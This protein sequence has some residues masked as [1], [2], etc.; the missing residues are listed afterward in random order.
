M[1]TAHGANHSMRQRNSIMASS[2][3]RSFSRS[4]GAKGSRMSDKCASQTPRQLVRVMAVKFG[5]NV[6]FQNG[7][8]GVTSISFTSFHF[9]NCRC[10]TT[11][12]MTSRP[13]PCTS[14]SR[15]RCAP[16]PPGSSWMRSLWARHP[17]TPPWLGACPRPSPG[18]S[19]PAVI[20]KPVE[21]SVCT[22]ITFSALSCSRSNV[23]NLA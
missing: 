18:P 10:L 9:F 19:T 3:R 8:V 13:C 5:M 23:S 14:R 16:R 1:S 6:C 11:T 22:K 21:S 4:S 2:S 7:A 20:E 12:T 15:R 17:T